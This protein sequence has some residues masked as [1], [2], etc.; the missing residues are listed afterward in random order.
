MIARARWRYLRRWCLALPLVLILGACG[1]HLKEASPLP[2]KSLYTNIN[3]DSDFG[4]RLR[5][6]I[7]A[8]SPNT[9]ITRDRNQAEVWLHQISDDQ[10]LRQ[11]AIDPD[12][13]VEEYELDLTFTFELIDRT[14]HV[15]LA[16]TVLRS[17]REL[18]YNDRIVQAKET[19]INRT[20]G[21]MRNA[22]IDQ[23]LRR[24]S[25]PDVQ[26]AFLDSA[27]RPTV[28]LPD[29]SVQHSSSR[30]KGHGASGKRSG[31]Y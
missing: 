6:A 16:P 2:F 15:L 11:L 1:F 26:A 4:A 14:G 17:V 23:I 19:E 21:D 3:L 9:R 22:L 5:R 18:P 29:D 30:P 8:N 27:Q 31:Q 24:I 28:P 7:E 25:A 13:R 10:R 20:F 12:G